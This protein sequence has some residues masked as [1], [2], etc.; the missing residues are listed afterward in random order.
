VK[1]RIEIDY[2]T[3]QDVD[4]LV[5]QYSI[6]EFLVVTETAGIKTIYPLFDVRTVKITVNNG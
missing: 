1:F 5:D 2:G 3:G 6:R 4:V